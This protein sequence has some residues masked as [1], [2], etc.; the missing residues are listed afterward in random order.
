MSLLFLY[1]GLDFV[2]VFTIFDA[3]A[4]VSELSR[5]HYPTGLAQSFVSP[6]IFSQ[7]F[8]IFLVL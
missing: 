5:L 4:S 6:V 8:Q 2:E 1:Y 7:K 3:F